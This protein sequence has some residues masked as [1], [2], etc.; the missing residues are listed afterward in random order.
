M[1]SLMRALAT[2]AA[3]LLVTA[4]QDRGIAPGAPVEQPAAR[5]APVVPALPALPAAGPPSVAD[6]AISAALDVNAKEVRGRER[7]AWRN[8]SGDAVPDLWFHLYL[9]AFKS[10]GTTFNRESG[11]QL[12]GVSNASLRAGRID[13]TSMRLEDG[14][15]LRPRLTFE[16]P[17]DGNPDDETVARVLLPRPVGPGETVTIDVE[18]T[19][20]LPQVY[21]RTGYAGDF[22][23]IG[24]WF[25]KVAVY[26]PAGTRGRSAGGWNAHQFHAL[27]EFYADF[28]HYRVDITVPQRFV[29]G[30]TGRR[31]SERINTD[32]TRTFTYDQAGVHDFAWTADPRF[33]E[34][35]ERFS[36]TA[37]VSAAEYAAAATLLGRRPEDLTLS[38]VEITLLM[39]PENRPQIARHI[40]AA[41]AAIK[42]FGLWYGPYP[43]GTLTIVDP[44]L[45]G[46][47]AGGMEYPTFITGGTASALNGPPFDR[48]LIPEITVIHE[49]GHQYWYGLVASNEFEEAWLDEGINSYSTGKLLDVVYPPTESF[50]TLFGLTF[51]ETEFARFDNTRAM[52]A[53]RVRQPSW[54][55]LEDRVYAYSVY[56]KPELVLGTL[57]R[58]IGEQTMA[59]VMRAYAERWRFRHPNSDDFYAV[60]S[61]VSGRDLTTFFKQTIEDTG[62]LD[63]EL[64]EIASAGTGASRTSTVLVRRLGKIQVPVEIEIRFEGGAVERRTWDGRDRWTRLTFTRP[65]AVESARIDPDHTLRLDVS[66]INNARRA[67]PDRRVAVKWTSRWWFWMQNLL[68][69]VGA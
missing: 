1:L 25:P 53:D 55:F 41:K 39:Q 61:E 42:H 5:T 29:V 14:T 13:V 16:R 35:R 31:V 11:G 6:Y 54:T 3:L 48:V 32:A 24:Q 59:R 63:Y 69:L 34:V 27:S 33:V 68:S 45:A 44:P 15:D 37:D 7:I 17:D 9:N 36:G 22:F 12:R 38:D 8:P 28:G 20:V 47:G 52:N 65:E 18:F 60:A 62:V 26:E 43:Y 50:A 23:L 67:E 10:P 56:Y 40:A 66:W 4:I 57:E 19:S 49:F 21:A 51:S 2:A 58:M 46:E 64:A 30:A